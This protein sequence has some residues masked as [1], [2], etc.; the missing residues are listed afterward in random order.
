MLQ[1]RVPAR[2]RTRRTAAPKPEVCAVVNARSASSFHSVGWAVMP[3]VLLPRVLV[4]QI[5]AEV[6]ASAAEQVSSGVIVSSVE[7]SGTQASHAGLP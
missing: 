5:A 4:L 1:G 7:R 2:K 3:R 6:W